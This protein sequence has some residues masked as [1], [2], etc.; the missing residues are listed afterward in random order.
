VFRETPEAEWLVSLHEEAL[1][2]TIDR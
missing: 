1:H 2:E